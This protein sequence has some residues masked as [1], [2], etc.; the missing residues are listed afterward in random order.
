MAS[1][2]IYKNVR[3]FRNFLTPK[4]EQKRSKNFRNS[5]QQSLN[6]IFALS[7]ASLYWGSPAKQKPVIMK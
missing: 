4:P 7:T 3:N 5:S 1:E 6:K 2:T